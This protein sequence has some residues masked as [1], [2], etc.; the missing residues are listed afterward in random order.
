MGQL[1]AVTSTIPACT[2]LG[3]TTQTVVLT[4]AGQPG[5]SGSML[6]LPIGEKS[7]LR[8][9]LINYNFDFDCVC[10]F[11]LNWLPRRTWKRLTNSICV[12]RPTSIQTWLASTWI[13]VQRYKRNNSSVLE[14]YQRWPHHR[15]VRSNSRPAVS[16]HLNGISWL[17]RTHNKWKS[18]HQSQVLFECNS[19]LFFPHGFVR[20][21]FEYHMEK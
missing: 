10:S 9:I 16:S 13:W 17:R 19:F 5:Q 4:T 12:P 18:P 2:V 20:I 11:Q 21:Q 15:L 14:A 1:Q 6:S 8:S 3:Q 7:F